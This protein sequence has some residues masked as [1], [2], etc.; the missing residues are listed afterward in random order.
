MS[1]ISKYKPTHLDEIIYPDYA[2]ER[3]VKSLGDG[4]LSGH[5]MFYGPNGTAKTT[6]A[7]LLVKSIGGNEADIETKQINQLLAMN[8][9]EGYL[10]RACSMNQGSESGKFF[11]LFNEF[12]KAKGDIDKLWNAMDKLGDSLMLIITTNE[13]MKIDRAIR[14]RCQMI[15]FPALRAVS[16]LPRAQQILAAE[17]L[18]MPDA[19]VLAALKTVENFGDIRKY[20]TALD[21]LLLVNP[22]QKPK[23]IV[24]K[25][26]LT[27]VKP[28][29]P[30]E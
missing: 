27:V 6:A 17:G 24:Q 4:R 15:E 21:H 25:P 5:V 26:T 14:S 13:E 12:D 19:D 7:N 22:S 29:Q 28:Q 16:V 23:P 10:Q 8:D 9:L 11:L 18:V 30:K 2:T 20:M 3:C 1:V